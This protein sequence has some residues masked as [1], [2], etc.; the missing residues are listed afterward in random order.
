[1]KKLRIFIS[2]SALEGQVDSY[3]ELPSHIRGKTRPP[4]AAD[5]LVKNG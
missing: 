3:P 2:P 1:M 5:L 4:S